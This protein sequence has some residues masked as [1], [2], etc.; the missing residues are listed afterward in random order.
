MFL[1]V[2]MMLPRNFIHFDLKDYTF[3]GTPRN[4]NIIGNSL[5][6]RIPK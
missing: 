5:E 1:C 2:V 3:L 4:G 6:V